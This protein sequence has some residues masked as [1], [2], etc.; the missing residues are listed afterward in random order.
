[1]TKRRKKKNYRLGF[2]LYFEYQIV[3]LLSVI[4]FIIIFLKRNYISPKKKKFKINRVN[5][6]IPLLNKIPRT[7]KIC[8][9]SR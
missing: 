6:I 1:M 3:L 8:V 7:I 9:K 5:L 2:P 4:I